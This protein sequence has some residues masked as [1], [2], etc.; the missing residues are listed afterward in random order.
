MPRGYAF[1]GIDE[2]LLDLLCYAVHGADDVVVAAIEREMV[3][4]VWPC[5]ARLAWLSCPPCRNWCNIITIEYP[6]AP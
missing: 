1:L 4:F 6:G 5:F 3:R 2:V